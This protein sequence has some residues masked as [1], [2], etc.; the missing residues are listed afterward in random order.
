MDSQD[1]P[2][3]GTDVTTE[4]QHELKSLILDAF[5]NGAELEGTWEVT[6]PVE[7]APDWTIE[8]S[9]TSAAET[10]SY[11]PDYITD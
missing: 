1:G 11:D 4:F 9:K 10:A 8:I 5:T 7:A 6:V 2:D 3:E